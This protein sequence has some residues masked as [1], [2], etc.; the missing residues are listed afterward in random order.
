[1]KLPKCEIALPRGYRW[2][3]K[4]ERM[5]QSDLTFKAQYGGALHLE[6]LTVGIIATIFPK[7]LGDK[8]AIRKK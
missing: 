5:R 6:W 4:G 1:M 3:K 2:L 8:M 7:C